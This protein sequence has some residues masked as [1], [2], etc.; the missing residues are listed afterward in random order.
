MGRPGG[1][2]HDVTGR[3]SLRV[4]E[5]MEGTGSVS[6]VASAAEMEGVPLPGLGPDSLRPR[7]PHGRAQRVTGKYGGRAVTPAGKAGPAPRTPGP[8]S[9]WAP[10]W[11]LQRSSLRPHSPKSAGRDALP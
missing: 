1:F 9:R 6:M 3:G 4:L 7:R 10:H 11:V 5:R 2:R 8:S